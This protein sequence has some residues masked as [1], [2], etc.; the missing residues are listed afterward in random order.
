MNRNKKVAAAPF[1]PN[2]ENNK[3]IINSE[4]VQ[5]DACYLKYQTPEDLEHHLI[6]NYIC[7]EWL[8]LGKTEIEAHR[9][10]CY[11]NI[12]YNHA[13]GIGVQRLVPLA[14]NKI[15]LENYFSNYYLE[16]D[17]FLAMLDYL[18]RVLNR[19]FI[20]YFD[21]DVANVIKKLYFSNMF[22]KVINN[23]IEHP[24][25]NDSDDGNY[26]LAPEYVEQ[27][28]K[29]KYKYLDKLLLNLLK[30]NYY[31]KYVNL[32]LVF[33]SNEKLPN[34]IRDMFIKKK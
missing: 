27:N 14:L 34:N 2:Y 28:I 15:N 24:P 32:K 22:N 7:R 1:S 9:S 30:D 3:K 8:K 25:T 29:N 31:K 23:L 10:E 26:I 19:C 16:T 13:S 33:K 12:F 17:I 6:S 18:N 5:C 11:P 4:F 21:K 20:K